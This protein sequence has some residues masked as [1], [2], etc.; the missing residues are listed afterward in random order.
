MN[1]GEEKAELKRKSRRCSLSDAYAFVSNRCPRQQQARLSAL[2]TMVRRPIQ[3]PKPAV[4]RFRVCRMTHA[5]LVQVLNFAMTRAIA[6]RSLAALALIGSR[7]PGCHREIQ[8]RR[9]GAGV[10]ADPAR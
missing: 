6:A 3:L 9:D 10:A 8:P 1:F 7:A 5:L 2:A 4:A